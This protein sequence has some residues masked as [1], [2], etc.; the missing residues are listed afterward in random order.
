VAPAFKSN[1]S[2]LVVPLLV[3][4]L[5]ALSLSLAFSS[6]A[7]AQLPAACEQYPDLDI[8][9]DPT[10]DDGENDDVGPGAG[11]D[12]NGTGDGDDTL[13][14]TGY[15]LTSLILLLLALLITGLTVR[16]YIGVRDRLRDGSSTG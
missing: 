10:V 1:R 8:C 5:A 15:P 3:L 9:I 4:F 16:A 7:S 14:F 6:Q 2:G 11:N 12:A 13:P